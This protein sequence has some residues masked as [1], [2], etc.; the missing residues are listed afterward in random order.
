MAVSHW[1]QETKT[2]VGLRDS[3]GGQLA[4]HVQKQTREVGKAQRW[5][6]RAPRFCGLKM[7]E[8]SEEEHQM[9]YPS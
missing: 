5:S 6:I 3:H 2:M 1:I 7:G 9:M 8:D 4:D